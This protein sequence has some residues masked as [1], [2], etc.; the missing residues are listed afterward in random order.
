[1]TDTDRITV[2]EDNPRYWQYK[3]KPVLLLGGSD[4]DNLFRIP[5]LAEHLDLLQSAGGNYVRCTMSTHASWFYPF[6]K[7]A[8]PYI[9]AH[10]DLGQWNEE[11]W[12][13][14]EEALKL[15]WERD[16]IVQIEIWGTFDYYRGYWD[17]QSFNPKNNVNYD[18]E[19]SGLPVVVDSH[20]IKA[21]NPFFWS[22]PEEHDNAI[23]LKYQRRFVDKLL[24][25]AL[26]YPNVLYCMDNETSVTPKWGAY[27]SEY[28]KARAAR[29]GV[30]VHTTEMWDPHDLSHQMHKATFDHPETYS[31]V[32]VSQNNHQRGETHW[33]NAQ[34]ARASIY[35]PRPMSN[36]KIYGSDEPYKDA[37]ADARDGRGGLFGR[38]RDGIERFW[39]NIFGGHAAC[40]FHRP[41]S[42]IGLTPKAQAQIRSMRMLTDRMDI[43]SCE[44]HN[45]LLSNR[46]ENA[47]YAMANPGCEYAVYFPNGE[48]VD[49]DLGAAEGELQAAWLDIAKSAWAREH[50][51][52]GGSVVTLSPPAKG[53]WAVLIDRGE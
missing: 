13:R 16:I 53:Y 14:F 24:D 46:K 26:P 31:F 48:A 38:T 27:W 5:N 35:P 9:V 51:V 7:V 10:Y 49:I 28:I 1:M 37:P 3:G 43:F 2:Y 42:G 44:P 12:E 39:R 36:V 17:R 4:L 19:S 33:K 18:V 32:E 20:P 21:E 52:P 29:E 11:Y 40:R 25:Y 47:A 50:T 30:L 41:P 8:E 34:K 22:V 15:A 23:V 45:D 6:E